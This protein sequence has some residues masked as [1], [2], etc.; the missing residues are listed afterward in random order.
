MIPT[1]ALDQAAAEYVGVLLRDATAALSTIGHQ[2]LAFAK[3]NPA[4]LIAGAI[5]AVALWTLRPRR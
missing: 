3:A 1:L 2:M 4:V 5:V